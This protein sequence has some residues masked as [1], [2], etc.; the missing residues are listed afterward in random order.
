AV[1]VADLNN[2]DT[3]DRDEAQYSITFWAGT[4]E[5]AITRQFPFAESG[6]SYEGLYKNLVANQLVNAQTTGF[7]VNFLVST[8][9]GYQFAGWEVNPTNGGDGNPIPTE[10]L[11]GPISG[12]PHGNLETSLPST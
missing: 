2:D 3:P 10:W 4:T 6:G 9:N 7:G 5:S 8:P 11:P 12:G 1:Y